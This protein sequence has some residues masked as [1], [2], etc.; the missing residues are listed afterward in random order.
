MLPT[1]DTQAV[2]P[3]MSDLN[4]IPEPDGTPDSDAMT[5]EELV[6]LIQQAPDELFE[7][8]AQKTQRAA[9]QL[10]EGHEYF[11]AY[12]SSPSTDNLRNAITHYRKAV[13]L[14]PALSEGYMSLA[15]ALWAEGNISLENALHYCELAIQHDPSNPNYYLATASLLNEVNETEHLHRVYN[16]ALKAAKPYQRFPVHQARLAHYYRQ[17]NTQQTLGRLAKTLLVGLECSLSWPSYL[18]QPTS[19]YLSPTIDF[20][21]NPGKTTNNLTD[22]ATTQNSLNNTGTWFSRL[23]LNTAAHAIQCLPNADWQAKGLVWLHQQAP[24]QQTLLER[25]ARFHQYNTEFDK[26]LACY[27]LLCQQSPNNADY[28]AKRGKLLTKLDKSPQ[29]QQAYEQALSIKPNQFDWLFELGQLQTDAQAYLPSLVSFKEALKQR[30]HHPMVLS[31]MAYTLF[32]LDDVEGAIRCY[33]D[34]LDNGGNFGAEAGIDGQ[35]KSA[36]AQ[37]LGALYYQHDEDTENALDSLKMAVHLDANNS[38]ARTM[39]AELLFELGDFESALNHYD[40]LTQHHGDDVDTHSHRGYILWQMDRNDEAVD[41]YQQA[42]D[43]DPSNAVVMNNLGVVYLDDLMNGL[44]AAE[45]FSSALQSQ[46]HYTL[47]AFNLGRAQELIGD[48]QA[49]AKAYGEALTLHEC[50]PEMDRADIED[51]LHGLFEV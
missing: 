39:L 44:K 16:L 37:T 40:Y 32:K 25:A 29:A 7:T 28:H 27:E 23:V 1:R 22:D 33:Q 13:E 8:S 46:P 31:N 2:M 20:S 51:R 35:W 11:S 50:N 48:R 38:D 21:Q 49:A 47:A 42:L 36:V 9:Q 19:D 14:D 34:A 6:A 4:R 17:F 12:Q 26:A 15:Q 43:C 30:P 45:L 24:S 18:S 5:L 10:T 41:A 3:D